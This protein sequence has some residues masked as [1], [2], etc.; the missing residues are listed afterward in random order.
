[1]T[2]FTKSLFAAAALTAAMGAQAATS[3]SISV[4]KTITIIDVEENPGSISF[5]QFDSNLGKLT[6]VQF[7]LFSTL[8][9]SVTLRNNSASAVSVGYGVKAGADVVATLAGKSVTTGNWINPTFSLVGGESTNYTVNPVTT[10][11]TL[12]FSLPSDLSGFVGNSTVSAVLS[13]ESLQKLTAGG[14]ASLG[15]DLTVD[16]YAVVTYTYDVAAVPEPETYAMLLAGLGLVGAM[17]RK[18]KEKTAA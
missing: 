10:S 8:Q 14:S 6:S 3:A 17:A 18:R 5:A 4:P 16:G 2:K 15:T 13:A 1:M 12:T 9:G 7:E 11:Q